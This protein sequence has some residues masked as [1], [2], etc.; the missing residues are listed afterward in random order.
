MRIR[1]GNGRQPREWLGRKQ[2]NSGTGRARAGQ[3]HPDPARHKTRRM[4]AE[5]EPATILT[6]PAQCQQGLPIRDRRAPSHMAAARTIPTDVIPLPAMR[7]TRPI[8]QIT[9]RMPSRGR[10]DLHAVPGGILSRLIRMTGL[11]IPAITLT[12]K[13]SETDKLNGEDRS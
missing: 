3:A 1:S 13:P 6:R 12:H 7:A 5:S 2:L 8:R 10:R 4:R 11:M 9:S